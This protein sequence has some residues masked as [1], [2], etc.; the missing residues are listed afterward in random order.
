MATATGERGG[1]IAFL[2]EALALL[3]SRRLLGPALALAVLLTVSNIVIASNVPAEKSLPGGAFAAAAFVR[4][5]GLLVLAVAILRMMTDSPRRPFVP[6]AGFWLYALTFLAGIAV[7]AGVR[8]GAGLGDS[9]GALAIGNALVG[10]LLA[11]LAVWF[12]ALA[13]A[14]P[15]PW[16]PAPWLRGLGRWL[17]HFIFWTLLVVTPLAVLHAAIDMHVI[18]GSRDWFWPL[19]LFDGP[20]SAVMALFG[21]ALIAAAYRRVAQA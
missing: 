17:P 20:L 3:A 9:V 8:A 12:A 7:T 15:V 16:S 13:V 19:M 6:D 1:L 10:V 11:P 18:K 2:R 4:V 5:A 14:R 21:I